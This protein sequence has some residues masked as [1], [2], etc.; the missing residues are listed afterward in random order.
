MIFSGNQFQN[1]KTILKLKTIN[2]AVTFLRKISHKQQFV[3]K[4]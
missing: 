2:N 4:F 1:K 3:N